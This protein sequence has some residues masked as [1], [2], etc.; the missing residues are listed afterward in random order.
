VLAV[1][2]A[3]QTLLAADTT[4]TGQLATVPTVPSAPA[5]YL[6]H[7]ASIN[8]VLFPC[9][10]LLCTGGPDGKLLFARDL[11]LVVDCWTEEIAA[12]A[13]LAAGE[14]GCSALWE[15]V[16]TLLHMAQQR[17]VLTVVGCTVPW[18]AVLP[19][20]EGNTFER[21]RRLHHYYG[22]FHV[23]VV[24]RSESPRNG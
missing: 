20:S 15:R 3:V 19:G 14:S 23:T 8:E 4:L 7:I 13:G 16:R 5:I 1:K 12:G 6:N 2:T 22:A 11:H 9:V 10:S 24:P 18:C 21:P 17:H